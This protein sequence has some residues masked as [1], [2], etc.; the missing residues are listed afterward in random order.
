MKMPIRCAA[1]RRAGRRLSSASALAALAT[2]AALLVGVPALAAVDP[3]NAVQDGR[4][5]PAYGRTYDEDHYSPLKE[6]TA[7]NVSGLKLAWHHDLPTMI[8]SFGAPLEVGGVLYFGVGYSVVYALDAASGRVLWTYDPK[9]TE[10]AGEKLRTAHGIRG[11]AYWQGRIITGTQDG[12]LIA[13][14]A[15]T[16]RPIWSVQTTEGPNDGRYIT[17]APRVF[18]GKVIIGQGGADFSPV[19]GYVTAYD[20]SDGRQ[21]WRFYIV[22]G[23]PKKGFENDAMRIAA[24]TWHGEWWKFGGGGTVWNAITYDPELHRIYLGTGNGDPWN[25]NIRSPG[26]GDNLFICSIVALDAAT[27]R[28]LWHYQTNPGETWDFNS[29]MDMELATLDLG[30]KSRRVILH[31]PKNG[32]FYVIDR[33]TGKLISAEPF[34][35][36]TW[37]SRIDLATGRPV[38]NPEARFPKGETVIQPG[39]TGAHNWQPMAFSRDTHLV[40]I[41]TVV[42]PFHYDAK[43][44]DPKTWRPAPH[45]Q[46]NTGFKTLEIKDPPPVAPAA[47]G[48]LQAYDPSAQKTVW[49]VPLS[50][51]Y[52]GGVAVTAGN[53]VFQGNAEGR[54]VAYDAGSG[55]V[56]WSFDAQDGI[57]GQPITYEAG[58]RQFVTVITGFTG[59]PAALG[60]Q[61][62]QYGW[63]YRTQQR[64]VLTFALDGHDVLP[65]AAAAPLPPIADDP[66][67]A[68]DPEQVDR[69]VTVYAEHCFGCH[70]V[71]AVA[72]GGAPDLRR[73]TIP[74]DPQAFEQVV[75]NGALEA[76]GMPKFG[77]LSE[78]DLLALRNFLRYQARLGLAAQA[79]ATSR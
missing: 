59:L 7:G 8:S 2:V 61:V 53:V 51:P 66:H 50:A 14:D 30:G 62:A 35:K 5:W 16:G 9:V 21:L 49:E 75:R 29:A 67:F 57:I 77:E 78:P 3:L 1:P 10:V 63:D 37:A 33:D 23:D 19:R 70:G 73:S 45:L 25:Q 32:F 46:S 17:G 18:E 44:I 43:G 24:K 26:G 72:A 39:G 22:P 34:T 71:A 69:G 65:A 55:K 40:Y 4:D 56:L 76:R 64:R 52:N 79:K 42:M 74:L 36:V 54:F 6:I 60:P 13:I 38:E 28:Y 58:G 68:V 31:A 47:F 41:P 20:V 27:G 15:N 12:R 11:I 48:N